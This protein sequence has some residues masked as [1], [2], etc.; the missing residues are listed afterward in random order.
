VAKFDFCPN[1]HVAEEIPPEEQQAMSMNGW[2]FTAKPR[3]PYRPKFKLTL[4]GL[5]WHLSGGQ[6]DIAKDPAH[7]AGRLR[8]FYVEHLTWKPFEYQHEYLGLITCRFASPLILP[9]A[10]PS[11]SGLLPEI[12][13]TLI[14]HNPGYR[15]A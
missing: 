14:W 8:A 11:S 5:R 3:I 10:L 13:T 7:N 2:D 6:I 9:K 1:T 15:D 4:G 12:E